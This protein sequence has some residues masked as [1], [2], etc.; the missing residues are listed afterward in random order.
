MLRA[1]CKRLQLAKETLKQLT[2]GTLKLVRGGD[3]PPPDTFDVDTGC[4][5]V[6]VTTIDELP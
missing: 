1:R 4:T 2:T 5:S 6:T 3:N